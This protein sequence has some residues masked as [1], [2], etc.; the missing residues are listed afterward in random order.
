MKKTK[1][2]GRPPFRPP[3]HGPSGASAGERGEWL[4]GVHAVLAALGNPERMIRRFLA[5]SNGAE[6]LPA[7]LAVTPDLIS[8]KELEA[9]LPRDAVHQGLAVLAEPLPAPGLDE[10][11]A[12]EGPSLVVALDQV[13]DP[14][15]VGAILRSASA[16]GARA[17]ILTE[18]HAP[19]AIGTLAKAASGA[20]EHVP[21]LRIVN[22]AR[23]LDELKELGYE[24][25]GLAEEGPLTLD[26]ADPGPRAA[27]VLGAEG[28][29]LRRLTRERCDRLVRLP[30]QGVGSLN[31]SNAAAVALYALATRQQT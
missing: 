19:S 9:R 11:C 18:R 2:R 17:V 4:Y 27:L 22:L 10:V 1:S 7:Q 3:S 28:T 5:T 25:F 15:N 29:G 12:P 14:H 13:T 23:G 8:A 24:V 31:V 30:T 26:E 20:L 16:F 21:L 6:H